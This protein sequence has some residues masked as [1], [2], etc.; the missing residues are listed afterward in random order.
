[1]IVLCL[2]VV[3][4]KEAVQASSIIRRLCG[5]SL[6][7]EVNRICTPEGYKDQCF[8]QS[9]KNRRKRNIDEDQWLENYCKALCQ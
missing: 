3:I 1:M 9:A 2:L 4:N 8:H 6:I 7:Q 5:K